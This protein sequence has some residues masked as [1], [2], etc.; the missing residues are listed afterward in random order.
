MIVAVEPIDGTTTEQDKVADALKL[1]F[2]VPRCWT[3]PIRTQA[4]T[5]L[6]AGILRIPDQPWVDV[7]RQVEDTVKPLGWR[8]CSQ[9]QQELEA[10]GD[11]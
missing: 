1:A 10:E 2:G 3:T 4:V 9:S 5:G 8:L 11:T 7:L 6:A